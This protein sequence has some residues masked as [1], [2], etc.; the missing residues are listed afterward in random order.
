MVFFADVEIPC[1]VCEG[2]RFT[3]AVLAP[4]LR[5]LS[6]DQLFECT[7]Q[8]ALER[9]AD[10]G[11]VTRRLE[12]LARV[13]L[14]YIR[15]GQS[16][17]QMSG[18]ELQRLKLASYLGQSTASNVAGA[19]FIFDEPTVGLHMRDV[20]QLV[21]AMRQLTALGHTVIVVEHNLDLVAASDWV[22]DMGPGAGPDGGVVVY[23]GPVEGLLSVDGSRTGFHL[24][25]TFA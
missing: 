18:G 25:E 11:P 5:G 14:G 21:D 12:P 9:F 16:T 15:L 19:L 23:Q 6:I 22:V 3:P 17:T 7:V 13:G 24:R 4:K 2:R 8:E 20:E 1:D 10:C